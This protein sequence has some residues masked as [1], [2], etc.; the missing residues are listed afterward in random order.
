MATPRKKA[1]LLRDTLLRDTLPRA[2]L[3]SSR[4]VLI[5]ATHASYVP[6]LSIYRWVTLSKHHLQQQ[7]QSKNPTRDVS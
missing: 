5:S 4:L 2:T 1:I 7:R 6:Y 3:R